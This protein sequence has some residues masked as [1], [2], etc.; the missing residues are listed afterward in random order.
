MR[1]TISIADEL[2][3]SAKARARRGGTTLG[4]VI[5]EALR[6]EL[7]RTEEVAGP[8]PALPVFH[9]GDGPRPGVDLRSNRELTA[10]LDDGL[11]L[12]SRR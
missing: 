6:R 8:R 3:L 5:E 9:G 7:A 1:T 12:D 2:L 10:L 4:S 11:P